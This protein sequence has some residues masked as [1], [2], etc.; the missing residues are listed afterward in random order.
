MR[1]AELLR[2]AREPWWI[3]GSVAVELHGTQAGSIRDIDVLL[4]NGDAERYF[5]LLKLSNVAETADPLFRSD[6]F[7]AW[8]ETPVTI[9]LMA[10][11]KVK[12]AGAWQALTI[13]SREE[14]REGLFV[15]ARAELRDILISFGRDKDLQRA[16][17]LD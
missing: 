6:L 8:T 12:R 14:A 15:P 17:A 9:E 16:A 10:G 13:Q 7:A 4:G 2:D 3:I 1:L 5:R 11:L